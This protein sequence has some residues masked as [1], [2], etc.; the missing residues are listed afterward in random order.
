MPVAFH[1]LQNKSSQRRNTSRYAP[2]H[3]K[4]NRNYTFT[5]K[6]V[7]CFLQLE[8]LVEV[9]KTI[10]VTD[11][12]IESIVKSSGFTR[13][14]M[15]NKMVEIAFEVFAPGLPQIPPNNVMKMLEFSKTKKLGAA[16]KIASMVSWSTLKNDLNE[17]R[18]EIL[19][20]YSK[21]LMSGGDMAENAVDQIQATGHS[22]PA[23]VTH[24]TKVNAPPL[25]R[26]RNPMPHPKFSFSTQLTESHSPSTTF[27]DR[28][29]ENCSLREEARESSGQRVQYRNGGVG[30]TS[31]PCYVTTRRKKSF[32]RQEVKQNALGNISRKDGRTRKQHSARTQSSSRS[33]S[34]ALSADG[35]DRQLEGSASRLVKSKYRE[36]ETTS[37]RSDTLDALQLARS[38]ETPEQEEFGF[39][40]DDWTDERSPAIRSNACAEDSIRSRQA[41]SP[42]TITLRKLAELREQIIEEKRTGVWFQR[43]R[44]R[45]GFMDSPD[46]DYTFSDACRSPRTRQQCTFAFRGLRIE[47]PAAAER[48]SRQRH[49]AWYVRE[50]PGSPTPMR[51][52]VR[53][54]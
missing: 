52:A 24:R 37:V 15:E 26:P 33:N 48:P 53:R 36:Y 2:I 31:I 41:E 42:T 19:G 1:V 4:V 32:R 17:K 51:A 54:R 10:D 21:R 6:E 23:T 22:F 3:N 14:R 25:C 11:A 27:K 38:P 12:D 28:R 20:A 13:S 18:E 45:H 40:D 49:P 16:Y 29:E 44:R 43:Q 8:G 5:A 46:S 9:A 7:L 39:S 35:N 50:D 30:Q 47:A 34:T